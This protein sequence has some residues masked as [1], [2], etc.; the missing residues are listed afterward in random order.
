[1]RDSL[2]N[3]ISSLRHRFQTLSTMGAVEKTNQ[4]GSKASIITLF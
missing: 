1:M 2:T 4:M 3:F